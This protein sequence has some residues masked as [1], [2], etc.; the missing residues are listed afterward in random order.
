MSLK[1]RIT[2]WLASRDVKDQQ[3]TSVDRFS[4]FKNDGSCPAVS[5]PQPAME[6]QKEHSFVL[7]SRSS[8]FLPSLLS[9]SLFF[10]FPLRFPYD[11]CRATKRK[12]PRTTARRD[13]EEKEEE[14]EGEDQRND[15]TPQKFAINF[16]QPMS[17][18]RNWFCRKLLRVFTAFA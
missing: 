16:G 1:R 6:L 12:E 7:L 2:P 15:W 13:E 11:R 18:R 14:R 10:S 4:A 5:R 17:R 9:L 8:L 3:F